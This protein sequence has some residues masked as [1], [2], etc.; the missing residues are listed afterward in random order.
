M[1]PETFQTARLILRPVT[2]NDRDAIFDTYAHDTEVTRF[3]VWRPHQSREVT[4]A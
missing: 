1:F 3:L 2:P 4:S